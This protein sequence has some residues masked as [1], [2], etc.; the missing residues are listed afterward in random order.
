MH[1][2]IHLAIH[3]LDQRTPPPTHPIPRRYPTLRTRL[4]WALIETGL[5]LAVPP[6]PT[7]P[8]FAVGG[9]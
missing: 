3:R 7:D 8:D 1:P 4:G 2:D 9:G 6:K 5:R